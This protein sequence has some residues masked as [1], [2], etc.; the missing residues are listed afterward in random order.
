MYWQK[1]AALVPLLLIICNAQTGKGRNQTENMM[2]NSDE[3]IST[4]ILRMNKGAPGFLLEGDLLIQRTRNA[5]KCLDDSSS[6]LWP[7][8]DEGMV[9]VPFI[10]HAEYDSTDRETILNAMR[11]FELKTCVR[12][13]PRGNQQS[14]LSIEP[15]LGCSSSMG[16]IGG[17][18]LLSLQRGGCV[19]YGIV[20][21]ELLHALGFYH[22]QNRSD[23]DNYV[24]I[25]Y[26]NIPEYYLNNF[27]KMDTNNLYTPYD[28]GSVMHYGR[29][30]FGNGKETITPIPNPNVPIGQRIGMSDIDILRINKLY[31]C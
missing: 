22:E 18:Q 5:M 11:M 26:E 2:E 16:R 14:Y 3:D 21:H 23:R 13:V 20:Q 27:Q 12:F 4:I 15:N 24:Q 29:T 19:Y 9:D 25:H 8:S 30:A 28:Y 7:K 1:T 31:K 17:K 6:C 10:L